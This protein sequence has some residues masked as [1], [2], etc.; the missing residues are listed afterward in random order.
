MFGVSKLIQ[1]TDVAPAP[2][3]G[4]GRPLRQPAAAPAKPIVTPIEDDKSAE[5]PTRSA[6]GA[7]VN[8]KSAEAQAAQPAGDVKA[9]EAAA[10]VAVPAPEAKVEPAEAKTEPKHVAAT[11]PKHAAAPAHKAAAAPAAS[12]IADPFGDG[13]GSKKAKKSADKKPAAGI[14]DPF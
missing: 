12:G 9:A 2:T 8:D 5:G 13:G 11:A 1:K 7:E 14:V 3:R 6:G 10:P 4:R